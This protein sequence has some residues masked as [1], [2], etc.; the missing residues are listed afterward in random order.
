MKKL[1][2]LL[3][4]PVNPK[5]RT[6]IKSHRQRVDSNTGTTTSGVAAKIGLEQH[7][8]NEA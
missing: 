6:K 5:Y 8:P 7:K 4:G 1:I 3:T 2:M